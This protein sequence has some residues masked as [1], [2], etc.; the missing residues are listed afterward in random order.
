MKL[1]A[2]ALLIFAQ[3]AF[4]LD[5]SILGGV[6]KITSEKTIEITGVSLLG[7]NKKAKIQLTWNSVANTFDLSD[8]ATF[9][10]GNLLGKWKA[11]LQNS[12]AGNFYDYADIEF[13]PDGTCPYS[14]GIKCTYT[15]TGGSVAMTWTDYTGYEVNADLINGELI[16]T[17]VQAKTQK[18]CLKA[19]FIG[20]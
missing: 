12:C 2:L 6:A 4:A 10:A 15:A 11:Q 16:G 1:A 5:M 17:I 7:Q 18:W 8:I 13:K 20:P 3:S 19:T 9:D 14:N